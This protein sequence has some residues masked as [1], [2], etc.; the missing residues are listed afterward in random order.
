MYKIYAI[1]FL[2]IL[3]NIGIAQTS[4][5]P[6][7]EGSWGVRLIIRGGKDLDTYVANGYDYVE[8]AKQIVENYPSIGHVITNLTNNANSSLFTLRQNNYIDVANEI[9]PDFVPSLENEQIILDVIKVF[10]DAGIKVILYIN[11]WPS[12]GDGSAAQIA[13]W[14]AFKARNDLGNYAAFNLLMRGYLERLDGLVDG[15]WIDKIGGSDASIPAK[16]IFIDQIT[17]TNPNAVLG[18]NFNKDYFSGITV[19]SDGPD[20]RDPDNYKV[21]KY[22]AND[23]WSQFT[24]G[25]VTSIGGQ[26]APSNS[27]G[28]EEYTVTDMV[29]S[30]LSIHPETGDVFVKHMF[31][32]IRRRW[33]LN[34]EPIMYSKDQAYRMVKRITDAGA[35]ITFSTTITTGGMAMPDELE[36]LTHVN[37]QLMANADYVPYTRPEGAYLV[38]ETAPNYHQIIDFNEIP[39]KQV[40]DVDFFPFAHASSGDPVTLTSSNTNVAT[41]VNNKIRIK[42]AGTTNI[43]AS[44]NGNNTFAAASNV[45]KK[46]TVTNG[47][48]GT[49]NENLALTGIATQSTTLNNAVASRAIDGNTDGVFSRSSVTAAAGPD[50]WWQV[51]I[52]SNKSIGVINIFNR[53]DACC[54]IRLSDFTVYIID[55]NGNTTYSQTITN[56]PSPSVTIDASGTTG[57]VVRVESNNGNALNLAEVQVFK[58]EIVNNF[59][60]L[61][62]SVSQSSTAYDGD[63]SLAIDGNT[64]GIYS[65]G[66]VTHTESGAIGAWWQIILDTPTKIGDV[67]IFNRTD[68]CCINRLSDFTIYVSEGNGKWE[69][70]K[71]ITSAPNPSITV[72]FEDVMAKTIRIRSNT[73]DALSIAE[74]EVYAALECPNFSTTEAEA[75]DSMSGITVEPTTDSSGK[76]QLGYI[77][78]NDWSS[79]TNIDLTCATAIEARVSSNTSGGTIEVRLDGVSG[80]LIG[81]IMVP[82]TGSWNTWTNVSTTINPVNGIHDVYLVFTGGNGYLL[83][84]NWINFYKDQNKIPEDLTKVSDDTF[85]IYPNPTSD[86]FD[87]GLKNSDQAVYRIIDHTG[88]TILSGTIENGAKTVDGSRLSTGLYLVKVT[89]ETK[90]ITKKISKK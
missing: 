46:L 5:A 55:S 89:N 79:Y 48:G 44:Q 32:P 85:L 22:E 82:G 69:H 4:D 29:E 2:L 50:A 76:N 3:S 47:D 40:G 31:A 52:G 81:T 12:M 24:A 18:V 75:Y 20:E 77:N 90:T 19:D 16:S 49:D 73:T 42:G 36:V 86:K 21:I 62:G 13:G 17:E 10:R 11:H 78:N 8:A 66:S 45:T 59:E 84:L 58:G 67:K 56:V 33:S 70:K 27:W 28:Y 51:N 14:D 88:K 7:L 38:G 71:R 83:N 87:I 23:V 68:A 80:T 54:S 65:N 53:T 57:Q 64:D 35:S 15:Y 9:H 43:T 26:K 74:V 34:H 39:N 63:A 30:P 1:S 72:N 6:W 37:D 61:S 41:I 60:P 25:H